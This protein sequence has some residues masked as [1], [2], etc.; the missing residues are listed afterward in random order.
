MAPMSPILPTVRNLLFAAT[1]AALSL[2][3]V[4]FTSANLIDFVYPL[5][6]LFLLTVI[7]RKDFA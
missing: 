1:T 7:F 5:I 4:G 3:P 6:T 2:N